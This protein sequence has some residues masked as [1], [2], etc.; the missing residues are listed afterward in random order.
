MLLLPVLLL[1]LFEA[2][3]EDELLLLWEVLLLPTAKAMGGVLVLL[4]GFLLLAPLE[5]ADDED[6]DFFPLDDRW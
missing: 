3:V 5:V 6:E 2:E 4:L 1:V